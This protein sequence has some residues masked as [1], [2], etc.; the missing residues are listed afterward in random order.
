MTDILDGLR[1]RLVPKYGDSLDTLLAIFTARRTQIT[2][3]I[4]SFR[5]KLTAQQNGRWSNEDI[6][7]ALVLAN[8]DPNFLHGI[9]A[10]QTL[11]DA[12]SRD[13]AN[14]QEFYASV[15][16]EANLYA[17]LCTHNIR[18]WNIILNHIGQSVDRGKFMTDGKRLITGGYGT[19]KI[20]EIAEHQQANENGEHSRGEF[21]PG[22]GGMRVG[23]KGTKRKINPLF[24]IGSGA[25]ADEPDSDSKAQRIRQA[26][27]S[28][29]EQTQL[30]PDN[31]GRFLGDDESKR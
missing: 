26:W 14:Q 28:E 31:N 8:E 23:V 17:T 7:A 12:S 20:A 29:A 30:K 3:L 9:G 5:K 4:Q 19:E 21:V 15:A 27:L 22:S 2:K 13:I 1:L 18:L 25:D 10:K 6:L 16:E 24:T 11:L